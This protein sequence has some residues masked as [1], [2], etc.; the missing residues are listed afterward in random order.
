MPQSAALGRI[1]SALLL[2]MGLAVPA[3]DAG[4]R[5][6]APAPGANAAAGIRHA[7]GEAL[8]DREGFVTWR[9]LAGVRLAPQGQR[10]AP[11]FDAGVL[12]LDQQDVKLQGYMVPLGLSEMQDHFILAATAPS[13]DFCLPGGSEEVVEIMAVTP[14]RLVYGAIALS[15]KL[16]VL[17][18]D[19]N[20]LYY[21][22]DNVRQIE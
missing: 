4:S 18:N 11:Q 13:C 20:G 17:K 3:T 22:L 9:T 21:R 10:W 7:P 19:A 16:S 1:S 5:P 2:M 8:A 12:A 15:G 6:T 14:V